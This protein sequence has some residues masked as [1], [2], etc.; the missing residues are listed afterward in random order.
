MKQNSNQSL[1]AS[2]PK[3]ASCSI[4]TLSWS[5][6]KVNFIAIVCLIEFQCTDSWYKMSFRKANNWI[7]VFAVQEITNALQIFLLYKRT[8]K[9][10]STSKIL[11]SLFR[12]KLILSGIHQARLYQINKFQIF[13]VIFVLKTNYETIKEQWQMY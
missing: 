6:K 3:H 10:E 13:L 7:W 1:I 11:E 9:I 4:K 8:L 5:S 12:N 2:H